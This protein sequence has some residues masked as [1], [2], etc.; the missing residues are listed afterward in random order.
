MKI[1]TTPVI[2]E[3]RGGPHDGEAFTVDLKLPT[4]TP[5]STHNLLFF[6]V[7]LHKIESGRY[8]VQWEDVEAIDN[9]PMHEDL[10]RKAE[11]I[12]RMLDQEVG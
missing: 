3:V 10:F 12:R 5:T 11:L 4:D 7:P 6:S 8:Y 9:R 1:I 2:I